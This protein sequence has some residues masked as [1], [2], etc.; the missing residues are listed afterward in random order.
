MKSE[1]TEVT[2]HSP[3]KALPS[4]VSRFVPILPHQSHGYNPSHLDTKTS[5]EESKCRKIHGSS[6]NFDVII[7]L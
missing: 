6:G 5:N 1:E 3:R 2:H 4:R 7:T